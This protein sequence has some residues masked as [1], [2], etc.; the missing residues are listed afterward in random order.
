M[1]DAPSLPFFFFFFLVPSF[2]LNIIPSFPFLSSFSLLILPP[3]TLVY[4]LLS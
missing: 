1:D 2:V 3:K 4:L